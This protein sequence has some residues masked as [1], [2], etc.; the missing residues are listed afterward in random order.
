[1]KFSIDGV[2]SVLAS[3]DKATSTDKVEDNI[4][5]ATLLVEREA[6][7][8]CPVGDSGNLRQSIQ[9]TVEKTNNN[10]EGIVFSPLSY[11]PFV[12]YGTG[13]FAAQGN[14]RKDVPWQYQD[15]KGEWHLTSGQKP[16]PFLVPALNENKNE[17]LNI[18]KNGVK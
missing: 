12:E 3:I 4:T 10:I 2:N 9:S 16:Q 13:L 18:L 15:A 11:A 14:G 1:M 7:R 5:K 17:I 8:K 6:K